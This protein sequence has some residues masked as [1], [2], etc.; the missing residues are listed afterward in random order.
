MSVTVS[1]VPSSTVVPV[2]MWLQQ[3]VMA[4]VT[5]EPGYQLT[6]CLDDPG[7]QQPPDIIAI[8]NVKRKTELFQMIGDMG[9]GAVLET[10]EL[11]VIVSVF[12]GGPDQSW[13]FS[14]AW[15]L[16][17]VVESVIRAD[18]TC[19]GNVIQAH[20]KDSQDISSWAEDRKGRTVEVEIMIAVTAQI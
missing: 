1:N 5:S 2:K 18:P 14:R 3:Q 11:R 8:G 4:N 7:V 17:S 9:A 15:A 19:G 16:A 12:R 13:P 6:V 20:P 10:Y